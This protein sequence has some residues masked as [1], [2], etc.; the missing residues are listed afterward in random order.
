MYLSPHFSLYLEYCNSEYEA[1]YDSN[2]KCG[3]TIWLS[4]IKVLFSWLLNNNSQFKIYCILNTFSKQS[5]LANINSNN[6]MF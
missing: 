5:L 6:T 3:A 2:D 1:F 4:K